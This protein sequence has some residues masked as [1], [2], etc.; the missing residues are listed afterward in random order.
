MSIYRPYYARTYGTSKAESMFEK[1]LREWQDANIIAGYARHPHRV[2]LTVRQV[3]KRC[4]REYDSLPLP[5]FYH[6]DFYVVGDKISLW[7]EYYVE[8]KRGKNFSP[9]WPTVRAIWPLAGPIPLMVATWTGRKR[10]GWDIE[11]IVPYWLKGEWHGRPKISA[12]PTPM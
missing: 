2:Q 12:T 6:P 3:C 9:L 8:V 5:L 11:Y 4:G 7:S 10:L 1:E